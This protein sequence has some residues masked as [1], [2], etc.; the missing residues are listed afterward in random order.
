MRLL[1]LC[2]CVVAA[3]CYDTPKPACVFVC[4][5]GGACPDGY[6]CGGDDNRC[7]RVE[8][9]GGLATC[10]DDLPADAARFDASLIDASLI[11]ASLIDGAP[12]DGAA[13][14]ASSLTP[15]DDGS[16][17]A[18]QA[19]I[20]SEINP[21]DYVEVFNNTGADIDLDTVAYQLVTGL[22]TEPISGVGI[23][24]GITVAAGGFAELGWPAT[25]TTPDDLGG[26]VLLY[27]DTDTATDT[28]IMDFV[29]WGATPTDSH[30]ADA[31]NGAKWDSTAGGPCPVALVAGAIHRLASTDGLGATDYDVTSAPSPTTCSP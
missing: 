23:G 1:V 18:R 30:K 5:T 27:L 14:C 24:A 8:P 9:G 2:L 7:H 15:A 26:E 12:I 3:A 21:G 11:D 17:A 6:Q 13:A 19:L 29:C 4:G 20:L 16:G 28:Q 10:S 22:V 31:E 25:F